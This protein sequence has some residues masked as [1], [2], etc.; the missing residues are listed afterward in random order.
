MKRAIARSGAVLSLDEQRTATPSWTT[1]GPY[2]PR[3]PRCKSRRGRW[4]EQILA[5]LAWNA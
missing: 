5:G 4:V 1:P 2:T 3:P